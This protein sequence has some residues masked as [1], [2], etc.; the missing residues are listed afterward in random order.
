MIYDYVIV[1]SG[2]SG[3]NMAY[4]ILKKNKNKKVLILEKE[5]RIGGRIQ[6]VYLHNEMKYESGAI[7]FYPEHKNLL[8]LLKEFKYTKKDFLVIPN[9]YEKKYILTNTSK[10]KETEFEIYQ[11]LLSNKDKYDKEYLLSITLESYCKKVIGSDKLKYL[12][13]I[14]GFHHI[15]DTS[16][17]YGLQLI[18]RDFVK[19]KEFYILKSSLTEFLYKIVD[20]IEERNALINLNEELKNFGENGKHIS[21][22]TKKN[23]YLTKNLIL[24]IPQNG[25]KKISPIPEIRPLVNSVFEVPLNRMF[26]IYP[27][28]N[29]W[30]EK[31]PAVF[32]DT[33]IQR[34][35]KT[36]TRLVQ[37]SYTSG[38]NAEY[39]EKNHKNLPKL[40][41]KEL[42]KTFPDK[43]IGNPDYLESHF[44]DNGV[45]IWNKNVDGDEIS[46][47][48][49]KPREDMNLY[50]C[51]EAY[52]L[53]QRW[54]E[55][56][57]EMGN[58]IIKLLD[59]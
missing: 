28:N 5:E 45:H 55:G 51:N 31:L 16:A 4:Q 18:E 12:K 41:H 2:I 52:S 27:K 37:I 56:G 40:L 42:E 32:T 59:L 15:F 25:L 26:A 54:M 35:F 53:Q 8:K 3:L 14:N 30:Y 10:K 43:K 50:I 44:Y 9:N 48:I 23:I 1:G 6:S 38:K 29:Y 22:G 57:V 34:I 13:A 49:I 47:K 17:E 39:W 20:Y 36:G 21:V 7:R 46:N 19:V 11:K 58:R 24:A 33:K